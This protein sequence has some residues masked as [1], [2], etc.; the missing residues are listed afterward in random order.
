MQ[1]ARDEDVVEMELRRFV[2][3]VGLWFERGGVPRMAGRVL[4]WLLV[5]DPPEQTMQELAD[6]LGASMGSISATTRLLDQLGLVERNSL[7]GERRVRYRIRPDAWTRTVEQRIEQALSFQA[8]AAKG[9]ALMEGLD[10]SRRDRL[11]VMPEWSRFYADEL[12]R[13]LPKW[14]QHYEATQALNR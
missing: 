5:C 6:R 8:I 10:P 7:P 1:E 13:L 4:G 12:R 11:E 2:E 9:L 3:E 14:E